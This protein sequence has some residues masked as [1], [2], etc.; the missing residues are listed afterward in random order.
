LTTKVLGIA[1]PSEVLLGKKKCLSESEGFSPG[2]PT[3]FQDISGCL[4]ENMT[5]STKGF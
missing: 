3:R 1:S 4:Y 5:L 2:I